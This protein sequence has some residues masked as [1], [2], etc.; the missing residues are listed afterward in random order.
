M[1]GKLTT[2]V[3]DTAHGIP[4]AGVKISV[5]RDGKLLHTATTNRDGR[6]DAPLLAGEK[7]SPGAYRL[8]FSVGDYFAARG[9]SDA[10]R[11][12][13]VVPIA[14]TVDDGARDYHVPLL[15]SPWSY[16]TYRGS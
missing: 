5:Y 8:D 2:H 10:R 6:L 3:L 4:A 13:D 14:F 1:A 11:F 12:L 9:D 7:F 16:T 15:V